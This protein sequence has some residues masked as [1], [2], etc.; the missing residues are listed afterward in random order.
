MMISIFRDC[1]D[2][3]WCVPK[4]AEQSNLSLFIAAIYWSQ[5][6]HTAHFALRI[7]AQA[8]RQR[9]LEGSM[10][11]SL[12]MKCL[13]SHSSRQYQPTSYKM[14]ASKTVPGKGETKVAFHLIKVHFRKAHSLPQ[15]FLS[16]HRICWS[17]PGGS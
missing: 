6:Y 7:L 4:N 12:F 5:L 13:V 2:F 8:N 9:R 16:F 10:S 17:N 15:S 11:Q 1:D 3:S 14:L